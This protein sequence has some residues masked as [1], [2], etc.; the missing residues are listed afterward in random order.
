MDKKQI[1]KAIEEAKKNSPR[2]NFNQTVDLIVNLKQIDLKKPEQKVD[3]FIQL[4]HGRGKKIQI[5]AFV[6]NSLIKDAE[7]NCDKVIVNSDFPKFKANLREFKKLVRQY[8]FFL[9][10]ANLMPEIASNFGR[11]LGTMG[12]MPNPKAGCIIP[13]KGQTKPVVERLQNTVRLLTK[14]DTIV[15]SAIGTEQM[16]TEEIADNIMHAYQTLVHT[17]PQHEHNIRSIIIKL[18]MG[19]PIV[20]GGKKD[21]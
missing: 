6:D 1:I 8:D 3:Q 11:F 12:K 4:P 20:V 7:A 15:K 19:K 13:P 16:K 18:T 9:A 14:S 17:L 21:E 2:R 10:Q 5:C